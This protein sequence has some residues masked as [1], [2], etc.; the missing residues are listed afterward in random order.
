MKKQRKHYTPS[1]K[2]PPQNGNLLFIRPGTPLSLED[3]L[4]LGEG[5][6]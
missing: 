3:A 2:M 5:Y 6:V 4:R 1:T